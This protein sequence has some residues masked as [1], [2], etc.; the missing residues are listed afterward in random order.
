MLGAKRCACFVAV[1]IW[2]SI[3]FDISM[4]LAWLL[5]S[6]GLVDLVNMIGLTDLSVCKLSLV[7]IALCRIV[8]AVQIP[9]LIVYAAISHVTCGNIN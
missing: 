5:Y 9:C 6:F 3:S 1:I 2:N 4:A 8:C 7:K